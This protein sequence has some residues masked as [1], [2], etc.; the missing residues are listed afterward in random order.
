MEKMETEENNDRTCRTKTPEQAL[1]LLMN[2]CAKAELSISDTRRSLFRWGVEPEAQQKVIDTLLAQRFIDETRFAAAYVREK[3][4]LNRWGVHKIR[5]GLRAKRIPEETIA[6]A[7]QQLEELD[8]AGNLEAI[9]RRKL[10]TTRAKN[11]YELRGK[12][13]R[14]GTSQ[15]F[16]YEAVSDCADRL[17]TERPEE[18]D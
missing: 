17:V 3:A 4:R 13:L 8:M 5:S 1:R 18:D 14:Y 12:L 16:E 7:L 10:R 15:G 11:V 2:R 9:L 6:E